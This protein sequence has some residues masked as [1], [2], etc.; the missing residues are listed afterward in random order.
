VLTVPGAAASPQEKT[1]LFKQLTEAYNVLSNVDRRQKYDSSM[2][3]SRVSSFYTQQ[4]TS[5][6]SGSGPPPSGDIKAPRP[7]PDFKTFD[8]EE[9]NA[10]H[11]GDNAIQQDPF[12]R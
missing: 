2:G 11:Y 1:R 10:W 6:A 8:F 3:I 5:A 7:P 12:I 4:G 9:W